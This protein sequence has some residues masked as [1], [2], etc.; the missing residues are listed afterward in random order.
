MPRVALALLF[1]LVLS[2]PTA[3]AGP[4]TGAAA[5]AIVAAYDAAC[6]RGPAPAPACASVAG[7]FSDVGAP[8]PLDELVVRARPLV[9]PSDESLACRQLA[10]HPLFPG[11]WDVCADPHTPGGLLPDLAW[12]AVNGGAYRYRLLVVDGMV[13]F[14][15]GADATLAEA[16]GTAFA[17]TPL[18]GESVCDDRWTTLAAV[19]GLL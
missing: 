4:V 16:T 14:G 11:P 5:G 18:A 1:A 12:Q 15:P 7:L 10:G 9:C 2:L 8:P 13:H 19:A 6:T 3:A 17:G